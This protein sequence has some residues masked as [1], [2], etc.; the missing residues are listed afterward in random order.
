MVLRMNF[1]LTCQTQQKQHTV[2]KWEVILISIAKI[3]K[4]K[5]NPRDMKKNTLD[6][7][8]IISPN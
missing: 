3:K 2:C 4:F 6:S 8:E 1:H 7:S 5:K